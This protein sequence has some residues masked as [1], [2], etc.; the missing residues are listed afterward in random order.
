M[1]NDDYLEIIARSA[2]GILELCRRNAGYDEWLEFYSE[3][4]AKCAVTIAD[5]DEAYVRFG[6]EFL[7]NHGITSQLS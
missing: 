6:K 2:D 4:A 3:I 5:V 7:A 1:T